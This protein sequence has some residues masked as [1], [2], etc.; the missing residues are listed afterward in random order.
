MYKDSENVEIISRQHNNLEKFTTFAPYLGVLYLAI[1]K[2]WR[3]TH[4]LLAVVWLR[5]NPLHRDG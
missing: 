2:M 3:A 5:L 1:G 4:L